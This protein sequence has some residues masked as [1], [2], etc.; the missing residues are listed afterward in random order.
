L[1]TAFFY[2]RKDW[3]FE[4]TPYHQPYCK[5]Q[6][7][8][9]A[10]E[11]LEQEFDK[12]LAAAEPQAPKEEK[13]D[14]EAEAKQ[15]QE[16]E[17]VDNAA[18]SSN[19]EVES[20]EEEGQTPSDDLDEDFKNLDPELRD[21]LSK[22]DAETRAAQANAFRK[23]RAT[24]DKKLTEL[25]QEKKIAETSR[26]LFSKYGLDTNS[27][28]SQLEKLI[29]FEK[30]L[31]KDPTRIINA[32]KTKFNYAEK[33]SGSD[34]LDEDSLTQE[35]KVIYKKQKDI[36]KTVESLVEENRRLKENSERKEIETIQA[37]I[38]SFKEQ[39]DADGSLKNPYFDDLIG[40]IERLSGIYPDDKINKLYDRALRMNDEV[41]NKSLEDVKSKERARI[42]AEK[43]AAIKKAKGI[44]NQSL[45]FSKAPQEKSL[46]D[47]LYEILD[48]ASN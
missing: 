9:M 4:S 24:V 23:M 26:Q 45:K 44:N 22:A 37:E 12:I 36:E 21:I 20:K 38:I 15:E 6:A 28:F 25:G 11:D 43:Q 19:E 8:I 2:G 16:E 17:G 5:L 40:D 41:Y 47:V 35:E 34:E 39:K 10:S 29:Q 30:E 46:D 3:W 14:I 48:N 13:P 33:Q 32:L 1:E 18:E 7:S 31:E 27:G 42:E